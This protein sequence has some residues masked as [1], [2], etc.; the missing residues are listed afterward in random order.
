IRRS[1]QGSRREA[2]IAVKA[3]A[4]RALEVPLPDRPKYDT[5]V[6]KERQRMGYVTYYRRFGRHVD[7]ALAPLS[8]AYLLSGEERY[9][10]AAKRILLHIE[11]WGV[12]GTMSVMSPFGDEPGLHMARYGPR[13]YDWL[14]DLF[15]AGE[16]ERVRELTAA[17]AR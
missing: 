12:E 7:N 9:G 6:G 13:A 15:D 17:R 8:L 3:A 10:L 11:P 4:E 14:Y 5:L 16:R 2:W 1:L